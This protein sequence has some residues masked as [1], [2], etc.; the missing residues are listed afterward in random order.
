MKRRKVS[1]WRRL[2]VLCCCRNTAWAWPLLLEFWFY[3]LFLS[4][5]L[6]D[7]MSEITRWNERFTLRPAPLRRS[8]FRLLLRPIGTPPGL[9]RVRSVEHTAFLFCISLS[10]AVI[11]SVFFLSSGPISIL[12]LTAVVRS[13]SKKSHINRPWGMAIFLWHKV[14]GTKQQPWQISPILLILNSFS[15]KIRD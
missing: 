9:K 3:C 11:L 4:N 12:T 5:L 13:T 1:S 7:D 15:Q 2:L 10:M 8:P 6:A 14:V